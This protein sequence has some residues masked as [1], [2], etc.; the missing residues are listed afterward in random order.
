MKQN[1]QDNS[2]WHQFLE[3]QTLPSAQTNIMAVMM[4]A[5]TTPVTTHTMTT[6]IFR[7]HF[8]K[9]IH[10]N[11][12]IIY[13]GEKVIS[14]KVIMLSDEQT[15][16]FNTQSSTPLQRKTL[17]KQIVIRRRQLFLLKMLENSLRKHQFTSL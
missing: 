4:R 17:T 3:W 14:F 9:N 16:F 2:T 8:C 1:V 5:I 11:K 15:V 7:E 10:L 13:N 6:V 12:I